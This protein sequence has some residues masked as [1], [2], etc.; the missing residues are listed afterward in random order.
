MFNKKT[1]IV[2][3]AGASKEVGLP[4]GKELKGKI[5]ELLA[6]RF[7]QDAFQQYNRVSSADSPISRSQIIKF[8]RTCKQSYLLHKNSEYLQS[9]IDELAEGKFKWIITIPYLGRFNKSSG[10]INGFDAIKTF[11]E[12][13]RLLP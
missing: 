10:Q 7:F 11:D 8:I 6:D 12:L 1:L 13:Q 3:G 5:I 9:A 2:V 4:T